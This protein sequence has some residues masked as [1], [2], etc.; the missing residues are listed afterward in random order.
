MYLQ[1]SHIEIQIV[2]KNKKNIKYIKIKNNVKTTPNL[3][4]QK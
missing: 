3:I 2:L 1:N 4:G